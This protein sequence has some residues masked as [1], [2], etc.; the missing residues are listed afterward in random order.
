VRDS[1]TPQA[2]ITSVNFVNILLSLHAGKFR[3]MP[4]PSFV[5][6]ILD[7][8]ALTEEATRWIAESPKEVERAAHNV[9]LTRELTRPRFR[10]CTNM[11]EEEDSGIAHLHIMGMGGYQN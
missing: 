8:Q 5:E 10:R 2:L 4:L 11:G 9:R 3:A 6:L 1:S 7:G